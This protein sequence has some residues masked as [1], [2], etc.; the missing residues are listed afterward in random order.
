[1]DAERAQEIANSPVM[2]NVTY[3]GSLVYI[4]HVDQTKQVA[5]VHPLDNP[6]TKQSVPVT[7]LQEQ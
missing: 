7:N 6:N 2:V 4:E 1:M 3:N 5:T